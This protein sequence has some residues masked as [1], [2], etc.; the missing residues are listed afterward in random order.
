MF[1]TV[2][3]SARQ[4][5]T[6]RAFNRPRRQHPDA[7]CDIIREWPGS[8]GHPPLLAAT[9]RAAAGP[10]RNRSWCSAAH[11]MPRAAGFA[12]I[13]G[14]RPAARQTSCC[15]AAGSLYLSMAAGGTPAQS[16]GVSAPSPGRTRRC[17]KPRWPATV[18]ATSTP[19]RQQKNWGGLWSG[20]GNARSRP[21]RKPLPGE[22]S[23]RLGD[24]Q[25]ATPPT[26]CAPIAVACGRCVGRVLTNVISCGRL[27]PRDGPPGP[28][29]LAAG[30]VR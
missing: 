28:A 22:Y 5:C 8:L 14:W 19:R 1:R 11:C 17:G 26:S 29:Y 25:I 6:S 2:S 24:S 7:K 20:S 13:A 30:A 15:P 21:T 4:N 18:N 23:K 27:L 9:S 10:T 12:C 16:M 3:H